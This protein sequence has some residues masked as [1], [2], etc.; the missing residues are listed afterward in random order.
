MDRVEQRD[1][2]MLPERAMHNDTC[3]PYAKTWAVD[4]VVLLCLKEKCGNSAC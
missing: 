3:T 2:S 1:L 4:W